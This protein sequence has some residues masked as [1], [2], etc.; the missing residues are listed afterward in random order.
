MLI[1][2]TDHVQRV[3]GEATGIASIFVGD[4]GKHGSP[5]VLLVCND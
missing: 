4:D 3:T 2:I 1:L 5:V